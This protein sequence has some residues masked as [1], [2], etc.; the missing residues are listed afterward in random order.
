M[1]VQDKNVHPDANFAKECHVIAIPTAVSQTGVVAASITPGY[2]YEVVRVRSYCRVKA[3]AVSGAVKVGGTF[4]V[5]SVTFTQATEVAQTLSTTRSDN[6]GSA[7]DAIT[8]EY[9]SDGT[10]A[11]T[12]GLVMVWIRPQPLN[13]QV[14]TA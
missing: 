9:T 2:A 11:L 3:G 7:T 4:S 8:V 6:C 12:N 13:G 10:G 14:Y 5:A 1:A